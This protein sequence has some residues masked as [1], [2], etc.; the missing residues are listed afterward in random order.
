MTGSD[1]R[2]G[3]G[4]VP[5]ILRKILIFHAVFSAILP[6]ISPNLGYVF[7]PRLSYF[8]VLDPPLHDAS[9]GQRAYNWVLC[10]AGS[11]LH[12]YS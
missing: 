4:G 8:K 5:P 1:P 3:R 6:K 12:T 7:T 10:V 11:E 9:V 2:G